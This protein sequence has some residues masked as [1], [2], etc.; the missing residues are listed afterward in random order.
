MFEWSIAPLH[1]HSSK[2]DLTIKAYIHGMK[3]GVFVHKI[4]T[5][6]H[7]KD[8]SNTTASS[9]FFTGAVLPGDIRS[10]ITKLISIIYLF[11]EHCPTLQELLT[12]CQ[13]K[14]GQRNRKH[15]QI[16]SFCG[17]FLSLF[18]R[19]TKRLM[20]VQIPRHIALTSLP[21][22]AVWLGGAFSY[23]PIKRSIQGS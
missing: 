11:L 8:A 18:A 15:S 1:P 17:P 14:G 9:I 13:E 22:M 21:A 19:R 23:I 7:Y 3:S 5:S 12:S 6:K 2:A 16:F 20:Q 4:A 10:V